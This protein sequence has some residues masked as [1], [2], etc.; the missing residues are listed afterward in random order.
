ML[1]VVVF[2]HRNDPIAYVGLVLGELH[3]RKVGSAFDFE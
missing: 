2:L 3:I 1:C